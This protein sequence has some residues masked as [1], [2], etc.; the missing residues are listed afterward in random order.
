VSTNIKDPSPEVKAMIGQFVRVQREKYGDDWKE[1]LSA[2]M[3]QQTAPFIER[4]L[5]LRDAAVKAS[6]K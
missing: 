5:D 2:E 3:A 1:K 4:L 6:A